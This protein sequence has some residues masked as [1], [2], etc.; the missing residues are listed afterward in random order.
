MTIYLDEPS[1]GKLE[2]DY[3]SRAV[4]EG[5]VSTRSKYVA[6]F[7]EKLATYLGVPPSAV[8]ATNSGTTA[9]KVA[10]RILF[11]QAPSVVLPALTYVA[12]FNALDGF[13]GKV[14][15]E[16]VD[17]LTW[18]LPPE[19]LSHVTIPVDLYGNTA[20]PP[21]HTQPLLVDACESLGTPRPVQSPVAVYSFNH[22]KTITAGGG[23]AIV[24]LDPAQAHAARSFITQG[25][26]GVHTNGGGTNGRMTGLHAALGLAQL[27]RA[28]ELLGQK[29]HLHA[30]YAAELPSV[31]RMQSARY[32]SSW[33]M[34]AVTTPV[35]A[36]IMQFELSKAGIPS[37]RVFTPLHMLQP[38]PVSMC[39]NA[40]R[41]YK[42]G[43]C[44]P[45]SVLN[46][47]DAILTVCREVTR[48]VKEYH[49]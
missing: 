36:D 1:I 19:K 8:I 15:V 16:D 40:E 49:P 13:R 6:L 35:P 45:S 39:P 37:R 41:I 18:L 21:E 28:Y 2:L 42:F 30:L 4:R 31:V 27:E 7:E 17:T 14:G 47:D 33:W 43:I 46:T 48:I 32:G 9:L 10:I 29:A 24:N 5:E 23:G 25:V 26:V 38:A 11:R 44:L 3:V 20:I 34:T 22:N 12:T